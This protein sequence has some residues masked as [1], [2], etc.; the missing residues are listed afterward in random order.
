MN[1]TTPGDSE[2]R[3]R[4]VEEILIRLDERVKAFDTLP[5]RV[6]SVEQAV[7][8]IYATIGQMKVKASVVWA[9]IATIGGIASAVVTHMLV[10]A[11]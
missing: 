8:S 5:A 4:R 2:G 1:P 6:S 3:L 7:A 11:L 10:K 9:I